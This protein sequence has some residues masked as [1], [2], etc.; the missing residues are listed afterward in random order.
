MLHGVE[1]PPYGGD[2]I[3]SNTKLAYDYLSDMMKTVVAP[4][5]VHMSAVGVIAAMDS[6]QAELGGGPRLGNVEMAIER[7]AMIKG[8]VHPLVRTHP[9]TGHK[10]LYVDETYSQGIEGMTDAE[11]C[12]LLSFLRAHVTQ[13]S[14]TCRLH[15]EKDTLVLWDNRSCIHQAFNDYDGYRREMYR[16]TVMGEVPV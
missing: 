4:L 11:S 14:F 1:V 5:R 2:T 10:A 8:S 9:V 15:W 13:P 12:A 3:W 16:T 6:Q 7:E